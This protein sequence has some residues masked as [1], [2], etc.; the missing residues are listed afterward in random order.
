MGG[1]DKGKRV[2]CPEKVIKS[3]KSAVLGKIA[4]FKKPVLFKDL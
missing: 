2:W 3:E 1:G 4:T